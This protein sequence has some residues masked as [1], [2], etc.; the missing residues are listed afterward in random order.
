[1]SKV[2]SVAYVGLV[3]HLI[4]VEVDVADKGFPGFTIVGLA[5]RAVD[6]A[7]ERVKT[8]L[9]NSGFEFPNKKIVINLAPADLPKEGTVYDLPMAIGILVASGGLE[10]EVEG[11]IFYGELSLD[12]SLR[13][14]RGSLLVSLTAREKKI[15]EIYVPITNAS[16]ASVVGEV[17]VRGVRDLRQLVDHLAGVKLMSA[18]QSIDVTQLLSWAKVDFDMREVVGQ[19]MAKRAL[20]I[21]AA[22]GHNVLMSGPPGSGKTML[23]R[24]LAGILPRLSVE[25]ALEITKIY[26]SAGFLPSGEAIC[27]VRPF[28]A[29]HYSVSLG[30][31]IGGGSRIMPGEVSLAHLGVLFLDEMAE[32]GRPA[33]EAL[34]L[35]LE[36]GRVEI[37]RVMSRVEYPACFMLVGAVNPCPCGY[38]GHPSKE[39]R[40][41]VRERERYA[42]RISGPIMD[43]I[44]IHVSVPVT[45]VDKIVAD[46]GGVASS[47]QMRAEVERAREKQKTR[48]AG[49]KIHNNAMMKNAQ[50][51]K[52]CQIDEETS[53]ILAGACR[54]M[55]LSTRGYFRVLKL[56]RTIADLAGS[57]DIKREHVS[58]ALGY[59]SRV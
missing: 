51:K 44:D 17:V 12:G 28:R 23:A 7:R 14:S 6:E 45:E 22:G 32:F 52:Y 29:P 35:P 9:T 37:S 34:R 15:S 38:L 56:A 43:R 50:I 2:M 18:T 11:K 26:S 10:A 57:E 16:E 20:L 36:D 21:G 49:S 42:A 33:L 54:S 3:S 13:H 46:K 27:R 25:E 48:F 31:L 24:A 30:G 47:E 55:S 58:E 1:L 19:E 4:E 40:C 53:R 39:C 8:A 59:R 41:S 5:D